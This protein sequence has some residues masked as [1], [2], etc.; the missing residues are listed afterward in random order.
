ME[1]IDIGRVDGEWSTRI[2]FASRSQLAVDAYKYHYSPSNMKD[3][4]YI[5]HNH[6]SIAIFPSPP[7]DG[8]SLSRVNIGHVDGATDENKKG[9][10]SLHKVDL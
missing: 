6:Q 1:G 8:P 5:E 10:R 4:E 7:P 3:T 2:H 9:M